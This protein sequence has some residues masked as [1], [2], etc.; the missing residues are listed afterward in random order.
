[1]HTCKNRVSY[2]LVEVSEPLHIIPAPF[3]DIAAACKR[4]DL[5]RVLVDMQTIHRNLS[6]FDRYRAGVY[7]ASIIGP[8]I[9]AAVVAQP[10]LVNRVAETVAVN[11]C[12]KLKVS[13]NME[14]AME[15]L[16]VKG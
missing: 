14:E 15:W 6:I 8:K 7:V 4:E 11:R 10:A 12:G 2:L 9:K 16:G 1:M 3:Q 13:T 5:D